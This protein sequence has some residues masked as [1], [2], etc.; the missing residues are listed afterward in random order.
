MSASKFLGPFVEMIGRMVKKMVFFVSL[1]AVVLMAYGVFRQSLLFPHEEEFNWFLV[2]DIFFQPYWMIYGEVFPDDIN[3]E[4]G[5]GTYADG[6]PMV[7]CEP[8]RW[9]NPLIMAGYLLLGYLLLPSVLIAVFNYIFGRKYDFSHQIWKSDRFQVVM[10]Y[11]QRPVLPPPFIAISHVFLLVRWTI[12]RCQ[13]VG[14]ENSSGFVLKLFLDEE[15]LERLYDFEEECM[16][17]LVREKEL[18][19]RQ[20]TDER[21]RIIGKRMDEIERKLEDSLKRTVEQNEIIQKLSYRLMRLETMPQDISDT[22]EAVGRFVALRQSGSGATN[23]L[24][25]PA[26]LIEE[27][28]IDS[29]SIETVDVY[30][31]KFFK[32][33]YT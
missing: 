28:V 8:G 30:F 2:R 33:F 10:D 14:G 15:E 5:N 16:E 7:A 19:L 32:Y 22:L 12:R 29:T 11:E 23:L 13:A 6:T 4:C 3:P 17:G 26:P 21:V 20:S 9:L 18:K 25:S 24:K 31:I 1:I 27:D